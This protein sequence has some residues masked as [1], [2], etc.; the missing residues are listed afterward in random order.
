VVTGDNVAPGESPG[1]VV[2]R[3]AVRAGPRDRSVRG[4][5]V[6]PGGAA[7]GREPARDRRGHRHP[8]S[9]T[10]PGARRPAP[11]RHLALPLAP[12]PPRGPGIL[13]P[14]LGRALRDPRLGTVLRVGLAP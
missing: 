1:A 14:D 5:H 2:S 8:G 4:Q 12:G 11:D 13:L 7:G 3:T 6:V 9:R 10:L